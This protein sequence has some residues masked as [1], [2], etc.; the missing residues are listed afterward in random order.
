MKGTSLSSTQGKIE[1]KVDN[2]YNVCFDVETEGNIQKDNV[3][4]K[5]LA[6]SKELGWK[7][8]IVDIS[9]KDSGNGKRLEFHATNDN[10]NVLSGR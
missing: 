1:V 8:Y 4:F 10:K 9:S 3:A 2:I 7:N 6:N 5:A